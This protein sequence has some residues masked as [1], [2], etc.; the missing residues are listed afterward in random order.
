[1]A[2]IDPQS[3]ILLNNRDRQTYLSI[4]KFLSNE[5]IKEIPLNIPMVNRYSISANKEVIAVLA[6]TRLI[7]WN[8]ESGIIFHVDTPE[9]AYGYVNVFD[10]YLTFRGF[11]GKRA[12]HKI[13][14]YKYDNLQLVAIID[15]ESMQSIVTKIS[16]VDDLIMFIDSQSNLY[17][18]EI[19]DK[20]ILKKTGNANDLVYGRKWYVYKSKIYDILSDN[21][22]LD[23]SDILTTVDVKY[24]RD[25]ILY[26]DSFSVNNIYLKYDS[27]SRSSTDKYLVINDYMFGRYSAGRNDISSDINNEEY[28]YLFSYSSYRDYFA[29]LMKTE[30]N[31]PL[32]Y[33]DEILFSELDNFD[34]ISTKI[35]KI[36]PSLRQLGTNLRKA[37]PSALPPLVLANIFDKVLTEN[38]IKHNDNIVRFLIDYIMS[39][40]MDEQEFRKE[41]TKLI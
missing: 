28:E 10:K 1:M 14:I 19:D 34:S 32:S 2:A 15:M 16:I 29:H 39:G 40:K 37:Y 26:R 36:L 12:K 5:L 13:W 20:L 7:V 23:L 25:G 41:I 24:G 30:I 31:I 8:I 6:D 3:V 35:I 4:Y 22:I 18:Y 17:V 38:K 11:Y 27:K 33:V 21:L 9:G